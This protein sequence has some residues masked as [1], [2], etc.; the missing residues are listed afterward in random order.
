MAITTTLQRILDRK[1]WEMINP[2]PSQNASG[3]FV[4]SS[5]LA[6]QVALY[7]NGISTMYLYRPDEDGYIQI[8]A[9]GLS[10]TF[11][12]GAC[13]AW[14]PAGPTSTATAATST[15]IT[16]SVT[17]NG[18]NVPGFINGYTVR[19]TGGTGAGQERVIANNTYGAA[20]ITINVTTAWTTTPDTT[21]TFTIMSG[22]F[23]VFMPGAGAVGFKYYDIATNAWSAA[24]SVTNLPTTWGTDGKLRV[25]PGSMTS[26]LTGNRFATGTATAATTTTV[27]NSAKAWATNQ[28]ANQQVRITGGTGAGQ[29][30]TIA[31]NTATALTVSVAFTTTPDTTSTYYIEGNDDYIYL[32]GNNAVTMYRYSIS[33]NTWTALA[34]GTARA[35]A[36][37]S[38]MSAQWGRSTDATWTSENAIISGRRIYSFRG[39]G[40]A[41]LDYYDIPTN[42]WTQ[43]TYQRQTETFTTGTSFEDG[44]NGNLYIHKDATSRYFYYNYVQ[45]M[46]W[47]FSTIIYPQGTANV[48]DRLWST[49][50]TD[51]AGNTL[52]FLYHQRNSGTETFRILAF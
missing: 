10:G 50:F 33:G 12:A 20:S 39:G 44:G 17:V 47:P 5:G 21:S 19:I 8:P 32:L 22:R 15:S 38:G 4:I 18:T 49:N 13:G 29:V 31:S 11:G 7:V 30:R 25:T 1:Q 52:L 28:W 9:S 46:M 42:A 3:A 51:T 35:A 6:D 14:H 2:S 26:L 23:W 24:L 48:G 40:S 41:I 16:G 27:T 43:L 45:N 36:P 34:P 37:G